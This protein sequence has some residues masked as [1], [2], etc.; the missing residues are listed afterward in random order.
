VPNGWTCAPAYFNA[1]DGCDCDCGI[2]DPDCGTIFFLFYF[3]ILKLIHSNP[4]TIAKALDTHI[5][6]KEVIVDNCQ[7]S[8][9][10]IISNAP[11]I[12]PPAR[13]AIVNEGKSFPSVTVNLLQV[14]TFP[15]A[16]PLWPKLLSLRWIQ[17]LIQSMNSVVK[18][19]LNF[20]SNL[21]SDSYTVTASAKPIDNTVNV[22]LVGRTT[23]PILKGKAIFDGL[24]VL[25]TAGNSRRY[26]RRLTP[27][28]R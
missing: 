12:A 10:H 17:T 5:V 15:V 22:T 14:F 8:R 16:E 21:I 23:V 1:T 19:M 27:I 18:S 28:R 11:L 3:L 25:G 24:V 7:V 13:L 2:Y 6:L 4:S 26:Y 9:L 20:V